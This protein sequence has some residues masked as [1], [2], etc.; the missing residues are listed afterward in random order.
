MKKTILIPIFQGVEAK[1]I[2]RTGIFSGLRKHPDIRIVLLVLD[3]AKKE[4]FGAEFY[5]DNIV[6]EVVEPFRKSFL[7][8]CFS[9]F[10]K[11]LIRTE[12]M[13]IKRRQLFYQNRPARY[14]LEWG[15]NRVFANRSTRR[16][17]RF[18]DFMLV[19]DSGPQYLFDKY[20]PELVFLAHLFGDE[21]ISFLREAKRRNVLSVGLINSWD[22]ITSRGM[23][24]LLP[25]KL[26]VHNELIKND[27][28]EYLDMFSDDVVVTGIPHFD[29]FVFSK[30]NARNVFFEAIGADP[31]RRLLLFCP[32]GKSFSSL[33][34][35]YINLLSKIRE[36]GL[37]PKDLRIIVRFPPNDDVELDGLENKDDLIFERPGRRF[38]KERGLDWD[39]N[40]DDAQRLLDTLFYSSLVVCSPSSIS[41]DAAFFDKPVINICFK[42][43]DDARGHINDYYKMT[44]YKKILDTRGV[45]LVHNQEDLI[46]W[47]NNY[48]ERP[49]IDR[50]ERD[51]MVKQQCWKTDG[52]SGERVV[53]FLLKLINL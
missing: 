42:E 5:G 14:F 34:V 37:I 11:Y 3:Q 4:Y 24:R 33:D 31:E 18:L 46:Y 44:H 50:V 16:L 35:K 49:D 23:V 45:R 48:L 51:T 15:L 6:Y 28:I 20:D 32:L 30:P 47:V 40:S 2:L 36:K 8:R 39:M 43:D 22:K 1:N 21:E 19:R 38:G 10:K 13:D 29:N 26:V 7:E 27:A 25:E 52:R 41:I 17:V 12:T 9:S 53:V